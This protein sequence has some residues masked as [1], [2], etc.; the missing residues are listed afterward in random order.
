M[1]APGFSPRSSAVSA[2]RSRL[3]NPLVWQPKRRA[4]PEAGRG[5]AAGPAA[6]RARGC[7]CGGQRRGDGIEGV[8]AGDRVMAECLDAQQAPVGGVPISRR[9]GRLVSRL[10]IPKSVVSLMVVS[11][12]NA[13]PSLWYCLIRVC[14]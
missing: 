1:T 9:A 5:C 8:G 14:L 4:A 2:R 3:V 11:V 13:L 12:R 6:V 10:P 7:R